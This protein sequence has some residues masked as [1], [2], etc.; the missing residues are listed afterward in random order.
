MIT[1]PTHIKG[2][3]LDFILTENIQQTVNINITAQTFTKF[4]TDHFPVTEKITLFNSWRKPLIVK[5]QVRN[6]RNCNM[7]EARKQ[8]LTTNLVKL[9]HITKLSNDECVKLYNETLHKIFDEACPVETKRYRIDC[10]RPPW[11]N[12]HLQKLKQ[13]KR[14]AERRF[15]KKPTIENEQNLKRSRKNYNFKLRICRTEFY[16]NK[17]KISMN[18]SKQ[19]FKTLRSLSGFEKKKVQPSFHKK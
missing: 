9:N 12:N 1:T 7:E 5:K 14:Q 18:D 13:E 2:G 11:F 15:K 17:I 4:Q 10:K 19:L 8:L 3:L 6:L 16:H